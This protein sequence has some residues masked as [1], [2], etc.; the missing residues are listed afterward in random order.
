MK[1]ESQM[2][3]IKKRPSRPENESLREKNREK[4]GKRKMSKGPKGRCF[5]G[6]H[7]TKHNDIQHN[8]IQHNDTQHNNIQQNDIQHNNI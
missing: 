7:D 5:L 6:R 4:G 8:D 2:G 1:V 3:P